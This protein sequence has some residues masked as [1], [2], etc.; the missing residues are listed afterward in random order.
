MERREKAEGT[1]LCLLVLVYKDTRAST[2]PVF[3]GNTYR[4]YGYVPVTLAR[5]VQPGTVRQR[6]GSSRKRVP[7]TTRLPASK[8]WPASLQTDVHNGNIGASDSDTAGAL[9]R[10]MAVFQYLQGGRT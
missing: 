6:Y 9:F 4:I 8:N 5:L 7:I 10:H 1:H 2:R 3:Y